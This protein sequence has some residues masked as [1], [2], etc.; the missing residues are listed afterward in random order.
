MNGVSSDLS[1]PRTVYYWRN[2]GQLQTAPPRPQISC[3]TTSRESKKE[4]WIICR[5]PHS[6]VDVRCPVVGYVPM[7]AIYVHAPSCRWLSPPGDHWHNAMQC[8]PGETTRIYR[9]LS[10]SYRQLKLSQ[11]LVT[12]CLCYTSDITCMLSY[13]PLILYPVYIQICTHTGLAYMGSVS[14]LNAPEYIPSIPYPIPPG[15]SPRPSC[16]QRF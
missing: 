14:R 7:L 15:A 6:Y 16:H 8:Q 5:R 11:A 12:K 2:P 9:L 3:P 10:V 4:Y 1:A 13:S